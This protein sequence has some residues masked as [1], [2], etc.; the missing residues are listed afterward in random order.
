[1]SV[2]VYIARMFVYH[3]CLH[4]LIFLLIFKI[5]IPAVRLHYN[6]LMSMTLFYLENKVSETHLFIFMADK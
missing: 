5:N 4:Y 6:A 2:S 1:M 3:V